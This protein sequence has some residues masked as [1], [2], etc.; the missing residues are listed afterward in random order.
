MAQKVLFIAVFMALLSCEDSTE[1]KKTANSI[2]N[3]SKPALQKPVEK[4]EQKIPQYTIR[5]TK[6]DSLEFFRVRNQVNSKTE[7]PEKITDFS[8][9]KKLLKGIVE[10]EEGEFSQNVRKIRFRNGKVYNPVHKEDCFFVAYFPKEDILLCEGG[11]T[12]DVSFNLKNGLE[13]EDTGNPDVIIS[14]P[15]KKKRLNGHFEGQQC[16]HYFIQERFNGE[17]VKIIELTKAFEDLTGKWLCTIGPA[18]W[19]DDPFFYVSNIS[20]HEEHVKYDYYRIET[21]IK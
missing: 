8:K 2:D 20:Y 18:F 6:V 9:A 7:K 4:Q 13:T 12:T 16:F 10:F 15:S 11:H 5:L 19:S 14:S 17:Y 1:V 3:S 21:V